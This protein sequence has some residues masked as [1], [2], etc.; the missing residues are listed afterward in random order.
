MAGLSF[1][2]EPI[3][4]MRTKREPNSRVSFG[5]NRNAGR[6]GKFA[7]S[8]APRGH[9]AARIC[10]DA[11]PMFSAMARLL[12]RRLYLV[13]ERVHFVETGFAR[14]L[15]PAGQQFFHCCKAP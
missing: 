14:P 9:P 12:L 6:V 2:F 3:R 11:H 7:C 8:T 10:A 15:S 4:Q 5:H 1:E 13:P